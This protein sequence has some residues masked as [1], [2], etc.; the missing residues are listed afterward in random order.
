MNNN[1]HT[2]LLITEQSQIAVATNSLKQTGCGFAII[3]CH[4]T[5]IDKTYCFIY[6]RMPSGNA[7]GVHLFVMEM[8]IHKVNQL[9]ARINSCAVNQNKYSVSTH[10]KQCELVLINANLY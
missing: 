8:M 7:T 9:W 10:A 5:N 4:L 1:V 6:N 2:I 3:P